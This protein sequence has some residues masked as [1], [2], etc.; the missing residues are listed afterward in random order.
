M[1]ECNEV[2][3]GLVYCVDDNIDVVFGFVCVYNVVG[4][5]VDLVCVGDRSVIIFLNND[6]YE[7]GFRYLG[8]NVCFYL[9]LRVDNGICY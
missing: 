3:S 4:D 9:R 7:N 6:I 2:V 1:R 8:G 5:S